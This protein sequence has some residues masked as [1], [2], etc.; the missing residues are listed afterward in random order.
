M[1]QQWGAKPLGP[2]AIQAYPAWSIDLLKLYLV[3]QQREAWL[4]NASETLFLMRCFYREQGS[5]FFELEPVGDFFW[6][7]LSRHRRCAENRL[8]GEELSL[9]SVRLELSP[10]AQSATAFLAAFS[11]W[12]QQKQPCCLDI[13]AQAQLLLEAVENTQIQQ[14]YQASH[15]LIDD[16]DET[17]PLEQHLIARLSQ[18]AEVIVYTANPQGGVERVMGADPCYA[19]QLAQTLPTITLDNS[20]QP[21]QLRQL[22]QHFASRLRNEPGDS[23]LS[24]PHKLK[25]F[26][27][28]SAMAEAMGAQV[29]ELL[30]S[31]CPAHEIVCLSWHL[32]ENAMQQLQSH[33]QALG[34]EV[35]I[36]RGQQTLQRHPYVNTLLSL[37]RLILWPHL[38][39]PRLPRLN[40]LDLSQILSLCGDVDPFVLAKLRFELGQ[41][42]EAWGQYMKQ[43]ENPRLQA[44]QAYVAHAR[45]RYPEPGLNSLYQLIQAL[46]QNLILPQLNETDPRGLQAVRS[47]FTILERYHQVMPADRS[48]PDEQELLIQLLQQEVLAFSE[49]PER[50]NGRI[51]I[52]TL[53]RVCELKY[54]SRYQLWFDLTASSWTRPVN[55]PLDNALLLSPAWP[56]DQPWSLEA[57]DHFSLERLGALLYKGL[58]YV[59]ERCWF[60]ASQYDIHAKLQTQ[61]RLASI[62]E[63]AE[64]P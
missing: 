48:L 59:Q 33:F 22:A 18:S 13:L 36:L 55:H 31:G 9:R 41:N 10:Q 30:A 23:D 64:T 7:L 25:R 28:P 43:S 19:E 17:R 37:C 3:Q 60:Y 21:P 20:S 14:I 27:H 32:D 42:L 8:W 63:Y 5:A 15:W 46:W 51:K 54:Q 45:E 62:L 35:D 58:Q 11:Q 12:L 39:D 61:E 4:L 24:V 40:S 29:K 56:L 26:Q 47:L 38:N 16:L 53:Y 49:L 1:L 57:E 44:V 2:L 6:H 50:E 34:L 52:M